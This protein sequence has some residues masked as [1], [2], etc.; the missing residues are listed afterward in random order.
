MSGSASIAPRRSAS[1][2][3][4]SSSRGRRGLAAD[5]R[6][7]APGAERCTAEAEDLGRILQASLA[8]EGVVA[9]RIVDRTGLVLA[10][11]D[12]AR[13]G[14][15]L[16][17]GAFRQRLDLALDGVPQFV[18]PYPDREL[19]VRG[20]T[21]ERR[22]VA[23]FLA[24]IRQ[25]EGPASVALAMGVETDRQLATVFSAAR[26][27]N[28]AEA[29]AFSDDGL[30]LTQSR[31][32]E[33]LVNT[34]V[35]TDSAAAGSAFLIPVRDPGASTLAK[36]TCRARD[37]RAAADPRRGAGRRGAQQPR[38]PAATASSRRPIEAIAA[39]R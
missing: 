30:M 35:L 8:T 28:T 24:P 4:R 19:S 39:P 14:Q 15:R 7:Q 1:P 34:G 36:D 37:R 20:A 26:P 29:Y 21:D 17:S 11:K 9:F 2:G 16:S 27:G 22:P 33:E 18:R 13:C 38:A 25:G 5:A 3:T 10:S 23:W 31:F 32:A 6:G 12:P